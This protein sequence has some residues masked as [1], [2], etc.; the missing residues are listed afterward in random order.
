MALIAYWTLNANSNATTGGKNGTDTDM[1]YTT[2]S[3]F[4]TQAA[5]FNGSTS[6]IVI[7]DWFDAAAGDYSIEFW[8][9]TNSTDT[10]IREMITKNDYD[11]GGFR[12]LIYNNTIYGLVTG[13]VTATFTNTTKW[14]HYILSRVYGAT[15]EV[16]TLYLDGTIIGTTTTAHSDVGNAQNLTFGQV[17]DTLG[18]YH[19]PFSGAICEVK[20]WNEALTGF[21]TRQ[22][23]YA[24]NKML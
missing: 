18:T 6:K 17:Q 19:F 12:T 8:F 7:G 10:T 14:H 11:A 21:T 4:G 9:K 15:N 3:P 20:L 13:T 1:A 23:N 5:T 22:T 16:L 2:A 24:L